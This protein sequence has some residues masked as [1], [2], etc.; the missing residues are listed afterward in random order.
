[1]QIKPILKKIFNL[2]LVASPFILMMLP[3]DF[4][5]HNT[6]TICL[7]KRLANMECYACGLTR[8]TMHLLHFEFQEAW[9]FNKL[10]YLVT[11]LLFLIWL[12][13]AFEVFKI[14]PPAL[15]QKII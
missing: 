7:S 3:S 8:A 2:I 4:F 6:T 11:P 14:K 5:D 10:V 9:N 13:A 12:K 1:M 15:L